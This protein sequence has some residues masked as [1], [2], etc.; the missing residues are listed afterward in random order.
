MVEL[1]KDSHAKIIG[2]VGCLE[3]HPLQHVSTFHDT[4]VKVLRSVLEE[5]QQTVLQVI[6]LSRIQGATITQI[7][8]IAKTTDELNE[9]Y[10]ID[11]SITAPG[12]GV[13]AQSVSS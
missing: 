9:F 4:F 7:S 11:Q 13:P 6:R 5:R 8:I 1:L 12:T 10:S 2:A 3:S